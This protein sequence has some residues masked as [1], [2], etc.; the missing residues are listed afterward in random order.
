MVADNKR[1]RIPDVEQ[2]WEALNMLWY[3]KVRGQGCGSCAHW[4]EIPV[5]AINLEE[6]QQGK[7]GECSG[8]IREIMDENSGT[9]LD[10]DVWDVYEHK[11]NWCRNWKRR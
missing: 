6:E 3:Q 2:A 7:F 9:P 8:R 10:M 11:D 1:K 5:T 4:N